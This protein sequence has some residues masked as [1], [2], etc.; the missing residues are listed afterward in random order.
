MRAIAFTMR[1]RG[2]GEFKGGGSGIEIPPSSLPK[3]TP[4]SLFWIEKVHRPTGEPFLKPPLKNFLPPVENFWILPCPRGLCLFHSSFPLGGV[5]AYQWRNKLTMGP[6][7]QKC[8]WAPKQCFDFVTTILFF[9]SN[10]FP[11]SLFNGVVV[12]D[13]F[14]PFFPRLLFSRG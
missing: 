3:S 2:R 11:T 13:I 7:A 12:V 4:E 10:L 5:D 9:F 6:G 8:E 1:T 14:R